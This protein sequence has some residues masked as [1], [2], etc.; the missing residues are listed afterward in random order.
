MKRM[1]IKP[2]IQTYAR[3]KVLG[4]GGSGTNAVHRMSELGIRGVEFIAINTDAQAL[5]NSNA[6]KKVH[7]GKTVTRG[8]GAGM[9]PDRGREAAEESKEDIMD[10]IQHAD[11]VFITAGL[12]GG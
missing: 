2:K 12:G 10:A 7:I 4:I 9:N 1:Q 3:I 6:D 8:L 5:H 11:M